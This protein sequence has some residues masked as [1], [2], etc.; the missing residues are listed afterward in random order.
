MNKKLTL[1]V[2]STLIAMNNLSGTQVVKAV[3]SIEK[4]MLIT[5]ESTKS[6]QVIY[7]K[8]GEGNL[9]SGNGSL[10]N[11][12]ENIRTALENVKDGGTIKLIGTVLYT[13][14]ETY[15][16]KSPLPLYINKNITIEGNTKSDG[17]YLRSPIQLGANVTFK[18][19]KLEMVPQIMLGRNGGENLN[20]RIL[21]Q[22]VTRGA[23]IYAAGHELTL[24][25]V[26]TKF[27]NNADQDN[28]RPYISGGAYM[29]TGKIGKKAVI[30]VINA[31]NETK[32]S[33]IYAGDYWTDRDMDV[34]INLDGN[35]IDTT[36]YTG[37][38]YGNLKGNVNVNLSSKS[39]VD[40]FNK[41]NHEGNINLTLKEK[42]FSTSLDLENVNN[43]T[44]EENTRIT[45]PEDS[46]FNIDNVKLSNES[47]IDFRSMKNSIEVKGNFIGVD[48]VSED[49]KGAAI[50]LNNKQTL[51]ING[52]AT[53]ITRLNNSGQEYVAPLEDGHEYI[54]ASDNSTGSFR[55][56]DKNTNYNIKEKVDKKTKSWYAVRDR[57]ELE[58]VQWINDKDE[59]IVNPGN[60]TDYG[61]GIEFID[62]E[63]NYISALEIQE[64][65]TL[66][67]E[68]ED[69]TIINQ[70]NEDEFNMGIGIAFNLDR[71]EDQVGEVI[72]QIFFP[73]KV[74]NKLIIR[75]EDHQNNKIIEKTV[76][77]VDDSDKISG[78]VSLP[79][80]T[81]AGNTLSA[82]ISNI[83]QDCEG[84]EYTW[85]VDNEKIKTETN[86][87][88]I[89]EE[90]YV[91]KNIKVEVSAINKID[92]IMSNVSSVKTKNYAPVIEGVKD[93]TI[94]SSEVERF[95]KETKL[96][97]VTAKYNNLDLK[98]EMKVSGVAEKP[99]A[100]TS[101]VYEF[102]YEVKNELGISSK[103][104][105]KVTVT[106]YVPTISG[107]NDLFV[108]EG[109]TADIKAGVTAKDKEDGVITSSI[110]YPTDDISKFE[111]GIN[112]IEYSVEDNDG[113]ITRASRRVIVVKKSSNIAPTIT[114][115]DDIK[116]AV[117]KVD[118][119]NKNGYLEGVKA[120]DDID[121]SVAINVQGNV[122]KP[123]A[124]TNKTYQ[125]IYTATDSDGNVGKV[126]RNVTVTNQVPVFKG[127]SE[128]VI[129][130]GENINLK[131]GV[132][133][134]DYEDGNITKDI[135][136]P[137]IDLTKLKEGNH[138][139]V[140]KVKDSDGNIT[141]MERSIKVLAKSA[142]KIIGVTNVELK[143]GEVDDFILN[144]LFLGI[145][146]EDEYDKNLI[147]K[148][149]GTIGKPEAGTNQVYDLVYSVTNSR[150]IKTDVVRK[151][152]VTNQVPVFEGLSEI[153]IKQGES[154]DVKLGVKA[155]DCEDGDI[156]SNIIYP[157]IDLSKLPVG[158]HVVEY[159][160]KDSDGNITVVSRNV[161][162]LESVVLKNSIPVLV[163]KTDK[164][165][166]KNTDKINLLDYVDI[167]YDIEDGDLKG[168]VKYTING[169]I[170]IPGNYEV[171]YSIIDRDGAS[172]VAVLKL[173]VIEEPLESIIGNTNINTNAR[174]N[175][176]NQSSSSNIDSIDNINDEI[177][178]EMEEINEIDEESKEDS[179]N[180]NSENN[181]ES[182][183]QSRDN[184]EDHLERK[185]SKTV[186]TVGA[187]GA[188]G[189]VAAAA[190]AA[191]TGKLSLGK[192][193]KSLFR[194]KN[195]L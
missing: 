76:Y 195:G 58:R 37:G 100:G 154:F 3:E 75:V 85:F 28:K 146:V 89:V 157:D 92:K 16:D 90:K 104:T 59:R 101:E 56:I 19:M 169:D 128:I 135:V 156:T 43:L 72:L 30:N 182:Y 116:I 177:V 49:K 81:V 106:N 150:G 95:N 87:E 47:I 110:V 186:K 40:K 38:I 158:T 94:K 132:S 74:G 64:K 164:V 152:T 145:T 12:Y 117:G 171:L 23:T 57:K 180:L 93:I 6:S 184:S 1:L 163:L 96:E 119:F 44:M 60:N 17:L 107:L 24:D 73:E 51:N 189:G 86:N 166:I 111:A 130:E 140:Y 32:I 192:I 21:G 185:S 35:L 25:G 105:R 48:K 31:A 69:G 78:T 133:V 190:A 175:I 97:G 126:L 4:D 125:L 26:N 120:T 131:S 159:K 160:V 112:T 39:N 52:N 18:N 83:S 66:T 7:V 9:N 115:A 34:D 161:N 33:A 122:E 98:S 14:Y 123:E 55:I 63:G 46:S 142:P 79:N 54:K 70:D 2:L 178:E 187:V 10:N 136:Y 77:I 147:P 137:G 5:N 193:I 176:T 181:I 103:V 61:F 179:Q 50:L 127:L 149:S 109:E 84:L 42:F 68:K 80:N 173:E 13:K 99:A 162:V 8:G 191:S 129:Y 118:E 71:Y 151:I 15:V 139:V 153:S 167:A 27:G 194:K 108:L 67:V 88:F 168:S 11:P 20:L 138:K 188:V 62:D 91:G 143:V 53:G 29:N 148:I 155:L 113:N 45:L 170:K 141:I 124:G 114:G 36:I 172:A 41:T 22:E 183:S 121:K 65:L 82:D 102:I 174:E 165:S 144:K 134:T